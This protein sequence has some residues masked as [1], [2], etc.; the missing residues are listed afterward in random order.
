MEQTQ[1]KEKRLNA[2]MN[3]Q[4]FADIQK[5]FDEY[6]FRMSHGTRIGINIFAAALP[7]LSR[8]GEI[9]FQEE[10]GKERSYVFPFQTAGT[11][12][13]NTSISQKSYDNIQQQLASHG[14][15]L[16]EAARIGVSLFAA[17]LPVLAR[18]GKLIFREPDSGEERAYVFPF[19]VN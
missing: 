19:L 15:R 10:D 2:L 18:N 9:V 17:V 11:K 5:T 12:R 16:S 3:E 13:L 14:L 6:G 4:R 8:G 7:V 1:L